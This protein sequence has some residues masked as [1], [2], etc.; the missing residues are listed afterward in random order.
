LSRARYQKGSLTTR[1]RSDGKVW[2]ILRY[3][4][5]DQSGRR[6]LRQKEIGTTEQFKTEVQ[7]QKAADS[8][9]LEINVEAPAGQAT[10]VGVLARHFKE[11]ELNDESNERRS[12][13]TRRNYKDMIN[14][15]ILPRWETT[16][17][18]DVKAVALEQW[19]GSIKE[20][21]NP[22]KQRIKSIFSVMY[23]HA[24]RYELVPMGFN[25]VTLARQSCKRSRI[26]DI[27]DASEIHQLWADSAPRERAAI[28]VEYG[29]GLRI[30][31]AFALK[32]SDINFEEQ[33]ASVTKGIVKGH[34][35]EV[36]TEVSKKIVPLHPHQLEDLKAWRAVS[37]YA[38]DD[39]WVFASHLK[40]GRRPYW[41]DMILKRHIRPLAEKLGIKKRIGWH[42]FR[43]TFSTL[44]TGNGEDVKVTQELMRHANP[45]TTLALYA[46]AIPEN[47][48]RAQGKVV[49]MVRTAAPYSAKPTPNRGFRSF[50]PELCTGIE[51]KRDEK[52]AK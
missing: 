33:A 19:L 45:N 28:S 51:K 24:Q 44:L 23:T 26:P 27:L 17:L 37:T 25:P 7:A 9:R 5:T 32:W 41:P 42:T 29:N 50:V 6:V 8:L 13:S 10:T 1:R 40:R 36:K 15:W 12:W 11:V 38:G 47:V 16:K 2:W 39:D 43:R 21:A 48:R 3:R 22:T 4:I 46:Q 49:E 18:M 20:L 31:E 30:S 52:M 35:G 34:V 14:C